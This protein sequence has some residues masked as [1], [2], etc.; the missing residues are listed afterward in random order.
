MKQLQFDQIRR[1]GELHKDGFLTDEEYAKK[2]AEMLE[3][4]R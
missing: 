4:I 3:R 2:K 1:L